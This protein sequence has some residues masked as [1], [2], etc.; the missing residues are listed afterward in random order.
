MR[1]LWRVV[2]AEAFKGMRKRRTYVLAGLWWVF[3]PVLALVLGQVVQTNLGG[4]FVNETGTTVPSIVQAFA[5]PF[6]LARLALTGP[7]YLSPSYYMIVVA[8]LAAVFIGE[9]RNLNMWKTTLVAE[10]S[11]LAVLWGKMLTIQLQLGVLMAG[12]LA[13]ATLA[14]TLGTLFLPTSFAGEWGSLIGLYALQWALLGA[15]V[16]FASLLIFLVRN[17]ALGIVLTFFLPG[18][19]EGLYRL[20][21]VTVGFEPLTRLNAPFQALRMR[22]ALEDLPRY[23]FS[24]NLLLAAKAPARELIEVFGESADMQGQ[25]ALA[26]LMGG[27][28]TLPHAT[29]VMAGYAVLFGVLL[30]VAFLRRDVD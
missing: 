1:A 10:P 22:E 26:Q 17:V 19:L 5:S 9:E 28:L 29:A 18:L 4:S 13:C 25:G 20:W 16:L 30:T 27:A 6:G 8:L 14:G 7:A 21:R 23:F 2:R 24:D 3:L 12:A 11:R 15:A